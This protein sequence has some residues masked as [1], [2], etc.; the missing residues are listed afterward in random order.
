LRRCAS[1]PP[2]RATTMA[3]CHELTK[4]F[5]FASAIA[6][7]SPKSRNVLS[8][9]LVIRCRFGEKSGVDGEKRVYQYRSRQTSQPP[10][11]IASDPSG[12]PRRSCH[13]VRANFSNRCVVSGRRM[14]LSALVRWRWRGVV[15]GHRSEA[16]REE[17]RPQ[18]SEMDLT[19]CE[20]SPQTST[21]LRVT[22]VWRSLAR[23]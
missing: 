15:K 8:K 10:F 18:A 13:S 2:A 9:R 20:R 14:D 5:A 22:L 21:L 17:S 4:R 6:G 12:L 23:R 11:Q 7:G 3:P 19:F 1:P 16:R